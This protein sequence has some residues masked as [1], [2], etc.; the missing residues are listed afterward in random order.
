MTEALANLAEILK[1]VQSQGE[2]IIYWNSK[3]IDF[4]SFSNHK[5]LTQMFD[6]ILLLLLLNASKAD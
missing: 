4:F 5:Y 1:C 6:N 3:K 2:I